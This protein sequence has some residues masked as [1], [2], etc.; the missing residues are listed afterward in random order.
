VG[1][2]G[3][4]IDFRLLGPL[5]ACAN[6]RAIDIGGLK[7]R[8][9]LAMLL[10]RAN[11]PVPRGV[12]VRQLWGEHP[13]TG[14][15]HSLE[16]YVSRLRKTLDAVTEEPVVLTRPGAY[17]LRIAAEQLDVNRFEQLAGE[18]RCAL[19]ANAPERA[20]AN[21][22]E[23][24]ALW[25]GA[26][27]ADLRDEPFAQAEIARLEE[28]HVGLIEDRI[29]TDLALGRHADVVTELKALVAADPLRERLH[30]QLMI[31]LYRC[32]QQAEALARYQSA[33]RTLVGELGI[34]PGR[35]LQGLQRAIL[36]QDASLDPPPRVGPSPAPALAEGSGASLADHTCRRRLLVGAGTV[37]AV[38]L[39]LFITDAFNGSAGPAPIAVGP[40]T[41]A[42]IDG[43]RS[44][45]GGAVADAGRPNGV[46]YGAGA[47]WITDSAGD[48][49]LRVD[50]AHRITDRIPVGRG[51][52]GVAV[53]DGEVWVANE[54]DGTVSEVNPR[55]G[56]VVATI[57]VGNGPEAIG[58]GFGSVWVA[59]VTDSTLSRI[60]PAS[61]H[62][63][64]TIPLGS[65][66]ADLAVGDRGIWVT[67]ADTGRLLLTD[68]G[69]NRVS[70]AF[71]IGGL[72]GGVAV[73]AGSVWVADASGTVARFDP[74]T[75]RA[76]KTRVGGSPVGV[77]YADGAVWVANS[78][79]GGVSRIDPQTGATQLIHLGNDPTDLA[80]A[81]DDV[82]ATVL[83]SLVSHRGGTLTV[84]AQ[85]DHVMPADPAVAY[86]LV[87]WQ[88]L[89]MTN[90]GLVGYRHVGG[91][92]GDTLVADLATALPVPVDGGK[93]YMFKLRSSIKYSNGAPVRPEDFRRA[94]ER[95]FSIN[96]GSVGPTAFYIGILG[97]VQCER[98]PSHCDLARG[99]VTDDAANT[100]TFH[101]TA[102]DPEFLY[103]LAFPFADAVPAG[104]PDHEIGPTQLPAT[105]PYMTRS[106][107]Q[108]HSWTLVRN[109]RFK[110]WSPEAQPGGYPD[111][112][113]L[114][115]DVPPGPAVNAVERGS[116]DV[117]LS[118]PPGRI[119]ELAT[120]YAS[121][122]H[123]GPL[124]A[125]VALVLN[126]RVRPFNSLAA[127]RALNYAIDR[128]EMIKLIGGP[129][130]A[131]PT[132]QILPPA[133]RGY[134]PYCPYTIAPS[135]GGTWAAPNL[136]RAE[137]LV[138]ASGTRGSKVTLVIGSLGAHTPILPCGRYLVSVLRQLGYR[139]S[140]QVI[141][142]DNAYVKRLY[143]SRQ[144]TQIGDFSWYQDYPAPS[145]FI[146]PLLTCR[147][148]LPDSPWGNLNAAESCDRQIDAQVNRALTLQ[149]RLPN[150]AGG[151]WARIDH[152]LVDQAPWVPL[153]NPRALVLLSARVGNYQFH[154]YWTLLIDQ[155]WVR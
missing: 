11:E 130:T 85:P 148:F 134:Q 105:G 124:G 108:G 155:L 24:L 137:Q 34:E 30:Q 119:P 58:F 121:Q 97:G 40:N 2:E 52:A 86:F 75:G 9:L 63:I 118:P 80:A 14:A 66:P 110:E 4:V 154:P 47:A 12:L 82:W 35:A 8:A 116:S 149:T 27:L 55:A 38:T 114:R 147:S 83:P 107:R 68:P 42:V 133:M 62:V 131:Q 78:L 32:G 50:S 125:T 19:A 5:E 72:P 25:R 13:P 33:R 37:L 44:V 41:V 145:D 141:T 15:H 60:G 36:Q 102:P 48:L 3:A 113:V 129:L 127:R 136:A 56:T 142:N 151:L 95:V 111:R 99:I 49:L 103:K 69:R 29:A 109:P 6:G 73:G 57:Q 54:L 61:G 16:V 88:M 138:R 115:L 132:C 104:T 26:P 123:S 84:I 45:M 31:A 128:N 17:L 126:T 18:G 90:D 106:Y 120:R 28:L 93:T 77:A 117:L 51:P 67:S 112:I 65:A 146:A 140:L 150:A 98:T 7:Q 21:L 143:D 79:G 53:G 76:R 71:P 139:A 94:I 22:R 70:N 101:L 96:H 39:A 89:S 43:S 144:H 152:E 20:A 81:G 23:A 100:I 153:Y 46:A 92:A 64:A 1:G 10:L 135:P 122:L 87:S 91:L 74:L 59:N